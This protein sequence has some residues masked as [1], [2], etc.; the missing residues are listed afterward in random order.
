[1]SEVT[2][3][4]PDY[5]FI[6]LLGLTVSPKLIAKY[7]PDKVEWWGKMRFRGDAECVRSCWAHESVRETHRD[8][9]FARFEL[10]VDEYEDDP[11]RPAWDKQ[12]VCYGQVQSYIYVTLLAEPCLKTSSDSTGNLVLV[13]R[14]KMNGKD[15]NLE[16]VWYQDMG[17][18]QAFNIATIS[19][20]IGQ[21]KVSNCWGI[22]DQSFGSHHV[23][24]DG[25]W[26]PD[27]ESEDDDN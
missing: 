7:L 5:D 20:V 14:C 13:K 3:P 10:M 6:A 25:L 8:A 1:M 22:V 24:M 23:V 26:E 15:A 18:I 9:S 17:T 16:P 12:T 27:Y 2:P 4:D 11:G 19:C 21:I